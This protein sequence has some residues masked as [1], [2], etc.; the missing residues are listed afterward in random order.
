MS[1][2]PSSTEQ[3]GSRN[4]PRRRTGRLASADV[5]REA[6]LAL[7]LRQG[8]AGTSM[9]EIAALASV[10]KQTVYTHFAD[11]EQLFRDLILGN[12]RLVDGF[13]DDM[14]TALREAEEPARDLSALARRYVAF[15]IRPQVVLLR[16]LVIG[17]AS[18]FPELARTYYERAPERVIKAFAGGFRDLVTRGLLRGDDPLLMANHFVW[19]VL[20]ATLDGALFR[21]PEAL[22]EAELQRVADAGVR[23]FV[24]AYGAP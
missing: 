23:A 16:R 11:K 10:S 18:H 7:F 24:A 20:G 14:R 8:Y 3:R 17:E 5:I 21:G 22:D 1:T 12:A 4:A 19:L 2:G 15:V 6:A 13:L 9:D